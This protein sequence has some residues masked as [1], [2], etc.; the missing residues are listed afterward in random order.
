M[1]EEDGLLK[2]WGYEPDSNGLYP[3]VLDSPN[4]DMH[5]Y[6]IRDNYWIYQVTGDP[7]IPR[8]FIDIVEE[9]QDR[10][11]KLDNA[12]EEAPIDSSEEYK[13]FHPRYD[14]DLEEIQHKGWSWLQIDSIA[15]VFEVL[16][17]KEHPEARTFYR[18]LDAIE[19]LGRKEHGP[20]EEEK[21]LYAYTMSCLLRGYEEFLEH[22]F[23][24][25]GDLEPV[26]K[27][28]EDTWQHMEEMLPQEDM[29]TLFILYNN[30]FFVTDDIRD[31]ILES[32]EDLIGDYGAI[33]Y[34]GDNWTGIGW[35]EHG[36][37]PQWNMGHLMQYLATGE[38]K[39]FE[40]QEEIRDMYGA[41]PESMLPTGNGVYVP[42]DNKPL[43]WTE[44]LY[45]AAKFKYVDDPEDSDIKIPRSSEDLNL[46]RQLYC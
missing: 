44:A 20:W 21:D 31:T 15:N 2:Y 37:E 43:L 10:Y 46:S 7:S 26:E 22:D 11:N 3:A 28:I 35:K 23:E 36:E 6:W 17:E 9:L 42:N 19:P 38:D 25:P 14:E 32:T 12:I 27:K 45:L 24:A 33:R 30:P 8:A 18:Y 41:M 39:Y 13:H 16:S 40:R 4:Q 5:Q 29:S 34:P 1:S